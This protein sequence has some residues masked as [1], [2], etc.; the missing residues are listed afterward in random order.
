MRMIRWGTSVSRGNQ[1]LGCAVLEIKLTNGKVMRGNNDEQ[2]K[3]N[4]NQDL[5][6]ETK[7]KKKK[8]KVKHIKNWKHSDLPVIDDFKWNLPIPVLDSYEPPSSLFEKN[9]T[10]NM[11]QCICNE[12]VR[13]AEN[14]G[15]HSYNPELHDLKALIAILLISGYVDVPRCPMMLFLQ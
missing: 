13:Y 14:K 3:K 15:N 12:S 8:S 10:D 7:R 11:L 4:D 1:L 5:P 6:P 9:Y 2:N